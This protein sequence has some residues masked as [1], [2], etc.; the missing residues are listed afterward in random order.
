MTASL[1]RSP[2]LA[3]IDRNPPLPDR[4]LLDKDE[5]KFWAEM[6]KQF[7]IPADEICLSSVG[8][9][10]KRE[11]GWKHMAISDAD[12]VRTPSRGMT[13]VGNCA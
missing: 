5:D 3:Q 12:G 8:Q 7:L 11:R 6:R 2:L 13:R 4:S 9:R 10:D 1:L